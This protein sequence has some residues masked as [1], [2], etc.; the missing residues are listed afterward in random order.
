[1]RAHQNA[2]QRRGFS[3]ASVFVLIAVAA[4]FLAAVQIATPSRFVG[5]VVIAMVG[6]LG[7]LSG[8]VI[9]AWIGFRQP[10]RVS[11]AILGSLYGLIA[12]A[13]A[14]VLMA[15]P[16]SIVA[17]LVGSVVIILFALA[18]R[19]FSRKSLGP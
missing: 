17:I 10:R 1:M 16:E 14:G 5:A 13:L 19:R 8:L 2:M 4:V 7:P 15:V 11:G 18:T 3:L 12:G 6:F 9:G